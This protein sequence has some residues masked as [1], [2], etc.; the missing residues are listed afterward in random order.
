[1]I[2]E[3]KKQDSAASAIDQI[4]NKLYYESLALYQGELLFAGISYDEKE[5]T[6]SC[7]IER[8]RKT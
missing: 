2:I 6:H 8:F 7:R 3:L 1:M 5:K 4:K